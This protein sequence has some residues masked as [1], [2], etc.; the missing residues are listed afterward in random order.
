MCIDYVSDDICNQLILRTRSCARATA[1]SQSSGGL[2]FPEEFTIL[3]DGRSFYIKQM[4]L[5]EDVLKQT[6]DYCIFFINTINVNTIV[7]IS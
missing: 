5:Q 3:P 6:E 7:F 4:A 2:V 1:P